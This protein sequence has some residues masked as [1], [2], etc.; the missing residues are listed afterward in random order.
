MF[1][2]FIDIYIDFRERGRVGRERS[3]TVR[4][5]DWCF[6]YVPQLVELQT[7]GVQDDTQ[8]TESPNQSTGSFLNTHYAE[9]CLVLCV[10]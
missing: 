3:I 1:I 10:H 9:L 6:L 5:I 7:F 8:P 2:D 4:N